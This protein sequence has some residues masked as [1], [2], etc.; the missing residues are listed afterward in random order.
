MINYK[1][2]CEE[3]LVFIRAMWYTLG[4]IILGVVFASEKVYVENSETFRIST[5]A[6]LA[7]L[8][9]GVGWFVLLGIDT[10]LSKKEK[11]VKR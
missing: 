8:C 1:E 4:G 5:E 6:G 3:A 10:I 2:R 9:L 11:K 7:V